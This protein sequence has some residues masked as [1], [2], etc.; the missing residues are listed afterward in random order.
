MLPW[1]LEDPG[2]SSFSLKKIV[3]KHALSNISNTRER[4]PSAI[5]TLRSRLKKRGAAEFFKRLRGVWI[6]DETHLRVD[7]NI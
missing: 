3:I 2:E 4:V 1:K 6:S 5:Q 7:V